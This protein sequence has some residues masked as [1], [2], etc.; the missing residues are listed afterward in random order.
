MWPPFA[1]TTL[2]DF[3]AAVSTFDLVVLPL[4]V[5]DAFLLTRD[6]FS[7]A[8]ALSP[9]WFLSPYTLV[10]SNRRTKPFPLR[11][12]GIRIIAAATLVAGGLLVSTFAF[13]A[14]LLFGVVAGDAFLLLNVFFSRTIVSLRFSICVPV[15]RRQCKQEAK[16]HSLKAALWSDHKPPIPLVRGNFLT[17]RG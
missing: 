3:G 15:H 12:Q 6:F 8:I 4:V 1:A 17:H 11:S 7:K 9:F 14:G 2:L 5:V 10:W 13:T 16:L